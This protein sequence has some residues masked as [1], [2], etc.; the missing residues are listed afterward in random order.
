MYPL[1][2]ALPVRVCE[3]VALVRVTAF[4]IFQIHNVMLKGYVV[5]ITIH[6][7]IYQKQTFSISNMHHILTSN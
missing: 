5:M 2:C 6:Y 1:Y 7:L 3:L 4:Y